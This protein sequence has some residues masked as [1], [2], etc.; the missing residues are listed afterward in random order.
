MKLFIGAS[1]VAI[2][3]IWLTGCAWFKGGTVSY[4][5][6]NVVITSST[7]VIVIPVTST[8]KP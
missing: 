1:A 8:N 4:D 2:L 7:N 5:G 6:T 3:I